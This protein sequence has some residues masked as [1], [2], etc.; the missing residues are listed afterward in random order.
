MGEKYRIYIVRYYNVFFYLMANNEQDIYK[1]D[2]FGER[3][4]GKKSVNMKNIYMWCLRQ[5][6]KCKTK[7]KYLREY[8]VQANIWNLYS[9]IRFLLENAIKR[10]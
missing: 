6:I 7:F 5:N 9:Y 3:I 2:L 10:L 1:I 8:P 4:V